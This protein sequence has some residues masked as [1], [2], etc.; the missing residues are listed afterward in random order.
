M[1]NSEQTHECEFYPG[2]GLC[3]E[4]TCEGH[5]SNRTWV[6]K[7]LRDELDAEYGEAV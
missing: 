7:W 4:P 3:S 6:P 2:D 5:A 1:A